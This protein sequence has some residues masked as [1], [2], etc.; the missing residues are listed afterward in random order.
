[1]TILL[2]KWHR[3]REYQHVKAE[4]QKK[5]RYIKNKWWEEK[6]KISQ[7]FADQHDQHNVFQAT[8][9]IDESGSNNHTP[10]QSP[11]G[12]LLKD[13]NAFVML[14][15]RETVVTGHTIPSIPHYPERPSLDSLHTP[16]EVQRATMQMN[17]HKACK[18]WQDKQIPS[19]LRNANLITI[20]KNELNQTGENTRSCSS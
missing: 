13:D 8:K 2:A 5:I 18:I 10:L 12:I 3:Q 14:L 20:Y 15:N 7:A 16:D 9:A 4:I 1:M 6:A 19:D 11:D 17:N